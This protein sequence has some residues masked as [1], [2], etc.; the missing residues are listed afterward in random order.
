MPTEAEGAAASNQPVVICGFGELGQMV[1]N[2]LLAPH[3]QEPE[4]G[5]GAPYVAFDIHSDR[6]AQ[7]REQGFNVMYGDASRT[8][9]PAPGRR[10]L[11]LVSMAAD[12]QA[13]QLSTS[14][15]SATDTDMHAASAQ[16]L[17]PLHVLAV[18]AVTQL[19]LKLH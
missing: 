8:Q 13:A 15:Q 11:A 6:V 9:V 14:P 2:M 12:V 10:L 1:A 18:A 7:A 3:G 5:S 4:P 16:V 17:A 19:R